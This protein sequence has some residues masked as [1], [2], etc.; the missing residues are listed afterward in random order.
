M[1]DRER[2]AKAAEGLGNYRRTDE[3]KYFAEL[4]CC[5]GPLIKKLT[6][7]LRY[8]IAPSFCLR[9]CISGPRRMDFD[10]LHR[11]SLKI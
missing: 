8:K 1:V 9:D 3:E 11:R 4:L 5:Y 2:A 6:R 10:V 7:N